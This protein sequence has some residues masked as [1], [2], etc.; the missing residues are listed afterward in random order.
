MHALI[1]HGGAGAVTARLRDSGHS[2]C[3]FEAS[4]GRIVDAA[5]NI[6]ERGGSSLDAVTTAV[7][8]LEDDA[9]F[10]AGRGAGL[11]RDGSAQLDAAIM[12]GR[13]RRAGAV[14]AVKHIRN[15]VLLARRVMESSRHVMLVG[16]GAEEF[17]LEHGI[18]LAPNEYFRTPDRLE[19][20]EREKRRERVLPRAGVGLESDLPPSMQ[21]TV[22]AV[23]LDMHGDLAAATSTGGPSNKLPGRVGD[24]PIIG[25]GTYAENGVCAVSGTGQGEYFIRSVAAHHIASAVHYRGL[26]LEHAAHELIRE[27]LPGLGGEGGVIA[28]D[29]HGNTVM[30]FNT[31]GMARALRDSNGRRIVAMNR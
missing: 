15:P 18:A 6:L 21:G 5:F 10:N 11:A 22:G 9:L 28:V 27:I 12:N 31:E 16:P 20:L 3:E 30:E 2:I 24:S 17:A 7:C 13:D 25:A 29:A 19:E 14:A 26:T 8:M 23:A 4:L 1:I